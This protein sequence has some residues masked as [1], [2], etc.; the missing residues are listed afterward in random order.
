MCHEQAIDVHN[1]VFAKTKA[2]F[3]Y[4]IIYSITVYKQL[5]IMITAIIVFDNK[6]QINAISFLL[7]NKPS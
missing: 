4:L 1:I 3:A 6:I 7:N 2:C 5:R